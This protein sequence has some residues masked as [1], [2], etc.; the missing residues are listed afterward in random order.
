MYGKLFAQMFDGTLATKGPWQAMVTFQQLIILADKDGV[1]DMTVEAISRRTTIPLDI[2]NIGIT[3]LE[4]TDAES[5][6]PAEEG[7]RIA[8]LSPERAWGWRIVNHTHYRR[9]R[10]QEERR[11]YMRI[12]QQKRRQERKP[13]VNN[14]SEV[15]QMQYAGSNI[16]KA[17]DVD[18]V[19]DRPRVK[20][21]KTF[22]K[23]PSEPNPEEIAKHRAIAEAMAKGDVE[24]ARKIRDGRT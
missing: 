7:R 10:S 2:I 22:K 4:Q 15:N 6:T 13:A 16:H 21:S 20:T 1:V 14:V 17:V 8:R 24:L 11:E 9:I 23:I 3:A 19:S 12:Y 18:L 5:R